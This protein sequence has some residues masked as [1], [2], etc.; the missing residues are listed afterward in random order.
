MRLAR[1]L[2]VSAPRPILVSWSGGKDCLLAL[3]RLLDDPRWQVVGLLATIDR[4]PDR[5]AMH[6]VPAGLIRAQAERLGLP[7]IEMPIDW[8]AS[9]AAYTEALATA[10]AQAHARFTGVN[11]LAFG[12]LFLADIRAWRESVLQ[13]LGW[14]AV[15][16]LWGESTHALAT[17]FLARGH[18][19]I[20]STVDTRQLSADACGKAFDAAF[21]ASLPDGADPCGENGE[22]HTLCLASPRFALPLSVPSLASECRDGRFQTLSFY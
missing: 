19:A 7:L 2:N 9:N 4:Q 14:T 1:G 15:F 5:I 10:L 16:P 17:E 20:V 22:F 8:P 6:A 11:H 21:L 18:R 13:T 3:D 12:D